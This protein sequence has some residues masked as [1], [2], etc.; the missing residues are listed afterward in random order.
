MSITAID[1]TDTATAGAAANANETL[2]QTQFLELLVAQLQ[3][4]DPLNPADS[5]EFT[6]QLAQFSSLEQMTNMNSTLQ[7]VEATLGG[8]TNTQAVGYI[9]KDIL[10]EGNSL[11]ID[12]RGA[13]P[14]RIHLSEDA[15]VVYV[16]IYEKTGSLVRRIEAGA[17]EAGDHTVAWNGLGNS[18]GKLAGGTYYFEIQA[19][20]ADGREI[21]TQ[22][23]VQ[24]TVSAVTYENNKAYLDVNGRQI[25][26][27]DVLEVKSAATE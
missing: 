3:N 6:A 12:A 7:R 4:Q 16:N 23:Y 5:T 1:T 10:A 18:G 9:G 13:D 14:V 26:L 15:S 21:G 19:A 20:G 11:R 25:A 24:G 8:N 17:A 22:T 2:G 27:T